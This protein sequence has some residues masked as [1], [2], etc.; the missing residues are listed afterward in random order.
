MRMIFIGPPGAGKGT[1]A[2]RLV[3]HFRIQQRQPSFDDAVVEEMASAAVGGAAGGVF[4]EG[5]Q[6]D[7]LMAEAVRIV[8]EAGQASTSL[9]QRRLRV[10][11]ARGSRLLDMM[12]QSGYVSP[13]DGSKARRVLIK[14]AEYEEVFGIPLPPPDRQASD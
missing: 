10:G 5:K 13:A 6:E 12:E 1:Q 14:R 2:A 8:I 3:E 7:D 9:L 4:G 11:Y